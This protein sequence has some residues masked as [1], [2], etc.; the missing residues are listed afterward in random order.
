VRAFLQVPSPPQTKP[1]AHGCSLPQAAPNPEGVGTWQVKPP[2]PKRQP[3]PM[4][5]LHFTMS[6]AHMPPR[7]W[8]GWHW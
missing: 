2:P 3:W 7:D 8:N 1:A 5:L 4:N 6:S